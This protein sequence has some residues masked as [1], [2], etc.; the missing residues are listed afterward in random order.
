MVSSSYGLSR[1]L[2]RVSFLSFVVPVPKLQ[3]GKAAGGVPRLRQL[4]PTP[5][6]TV[7]LVAAV[8]QWGKAVGCR[9]KGTA[10]PELGQTQL[11]LCTVGVRVLV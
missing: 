3:S 1:C 6:F 8:T 7:R 5:H 10:C 4:F 9:Q 11:G 2:S